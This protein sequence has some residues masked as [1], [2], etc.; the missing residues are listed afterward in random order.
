MSYKYFERFDSPTFF[1]RDKAKTIFNT[2]GRFETLITSKSAILNDSHGDS[3]SQAM[4]N[5]PTL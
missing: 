4:E 1:S 3:L 2:E 5:D